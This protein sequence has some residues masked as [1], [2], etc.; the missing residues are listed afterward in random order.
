MFTLYDL[1]SKKQILRAKKESD[2]PGASSLVHLNKVSFSQ[3]WLTCQQ[4][5]L[6]GFALHPLCLDTLLQVAFYVVRGNCGFSIWIW[7]HLRLITWL[8]ESIEYISVF[9]CASFSYIP[10]TMPKHMRVVTSSGCRTL[11]VMPV[12]LLLKN[13]C[14]VLVGLEHEQWTK[15]LKIHF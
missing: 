5:S 9:P 1:V 11:Y 14:D 4:L 10:L 7:N 2:G 13:Y 3:T 8:K 6:R 12:L 15:T